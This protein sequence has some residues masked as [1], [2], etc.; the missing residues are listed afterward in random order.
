M[1]GQQRIDA[2]FSHTESDKV[3]FDFCGHLISGIHTKAYSGLR[4]GLGLPQR[5]PRI[6]H[7]RQQA[8]LP[9]DDILTLTGVDT[10]PIVSGSHRLVE[11]TDDEADYYRD[12][13]GVEWRK[14]R[15]DGL[16]YELYRSPF[17]GETGMA[18]ARQSIWPD[19]SEPFR[20]IGLPETATRA[21]AG[22]YCPIL[23]LP[24]G[25]EVQDGC[26]FT[27]GYLDF[28]MDIAADEESACYLLD[29]QLN[30]QLSWWEAALQRL[31]DIQVVRIGDD[32]GD[33]RTTL[34]APDLYRRIIKPRHAKLFAAIKRTAPA[35]QIL[36]H[37]DG[38]IRD[39]L[40]DLIE[41]GIDGLNPVQYT[42]PGMDLV[43][44]KR[45]FGSAL[46]FWGGALDTQD[47]LPHGTPA[48]IRDTVRRNIEILAP[49]GGFVCCQT[50]IIQSDVPIPNLL[51]YF[52]AVA[53][54]R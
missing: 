21:K 52:E 36:F 3:P 8:V 32:L 47:A 54:Y 50:H 4:A 48:Q 46:T 5:E 39:L 16:Y 24:V 40:P 9:D 34:M 18:V 22:G 12:E 49:G 29:R 51:A 13:L 41:I 15:P 53:E 25:L 23:D 30:M 26:F 10:R 43:N 31:P 28:F 44:L 38:A 45:D 27:R 33:Q 20:S 6:F 17:A 37:C 19:W 2:A 1:T 11:W 42:L 14:P 7:R 35:V